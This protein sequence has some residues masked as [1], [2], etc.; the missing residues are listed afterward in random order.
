MT[1]FT[2]TK[3]SVYIL[4]RRCDFSFILLKYRYRYCGEDILPFLGSFKMF[5]IITDHTGTT[6]P[7]AFHLAIGQQEPLFIPNHWLSEI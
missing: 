1:F 6:A 7:R 2:F 3:I 4:W 5:N